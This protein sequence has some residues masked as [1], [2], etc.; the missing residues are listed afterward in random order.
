MTAGDYRGEAA[1]AGGVGL[2]V[3]RA[4][5]ST[6]LL[7]W[8]GRAPV[9][10]HRS[11]TL[12]EIAQYGLPSRK[13]PAVVSQWRRQNGPNLARG[14]RR[15]LPARALKLPH[16]H[17]ALF[18]SVYRA[19]GEV[20]D[21]GL[22]G[23]RMV[24]TAGVKYLTD[25]MAAGANDINLFKFHGIGTGATGEA[26]GDTALGTEITTAYQTDNTR[27]TGTQVSATVGNNATYTTVGTI[28]VDATVANTEHGVLT[29]AATGGGTLLDRTVYSVV[30]LQSGDSLQATYVITFNSGG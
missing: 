22:A 29:Q 15:V 10:P 6:R 2:R 21:L 8:V 19:D 4:D 28:T 25:D 23:L 17:G 7:P 9:Y 24:T 11:P 13:L 18:L 12:R 5:G 30:T 20:I 1:P 3:I 26:V 14:L 16:F 27:P